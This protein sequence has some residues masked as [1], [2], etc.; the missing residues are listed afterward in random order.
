M[1]DEL[2]K[3]VNGNLAIDM[4][5]TDENDWRQLVKAFSCIGYDLDQAARKWWYINKNRT[6]LDE[7]QPF[8]EYERQNSDGEHKKYPYLCRYKD[9]IHSTLNKAYTETKEVISYHELKANYEP[10]PKLELGF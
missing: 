5:G 2:S 8:V 7:S 1:D 4:E 10:C 9:Y 3:F 6:L